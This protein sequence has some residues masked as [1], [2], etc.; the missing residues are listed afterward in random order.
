MNVIIKKSSNPNKKYDAIF[1]DK[2][3]ISF[4][5]AGYSDYTKHKDPER[6][7]RYIDRHKQ[8]EDWNDV[9]T[10]GYL[11]RYILWNKPTLKESIDNLNKTNKKYNFKLS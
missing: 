10:A 5:A 4:G 2:K 7:K 8:N 11:S 9:K 6:K 1:E 3:K